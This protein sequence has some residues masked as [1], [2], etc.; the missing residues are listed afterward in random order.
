MN[1]D[2][3]AIIDSAITAEIIRLHDEIE[4]LERENAKLRMAL[5]KLR[6]QMTAM[7][8]CWDE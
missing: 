8:A 2:P 4:R 7:K 1:D 5:E 3:Q 6:D